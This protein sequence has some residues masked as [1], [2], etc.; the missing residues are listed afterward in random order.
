MYNEGNSIGA[1]FDS[2][3]ISLKGK[4]YSVLVCDDGSSDNSTTVVKEMQKKMPIKLLQHEVNQGYSQTM[5]DLMV[6]AAKI[7]KENDIIVTMDADNTH[8]PKYIFDAIKL[9]P[10]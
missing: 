10:K 1:L 4:K 3:R 9:M 2:I 6:T 7:T 5:R 8:N